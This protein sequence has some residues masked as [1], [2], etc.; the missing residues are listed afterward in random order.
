MACGWASSFTTRVHTEV[1]DV[2]IMN[3]LGAHKPQEEVLG[4]G[5]QPFRED[6]SFV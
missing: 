6:A 3:Q 1:S 2:L 5:N 4:L